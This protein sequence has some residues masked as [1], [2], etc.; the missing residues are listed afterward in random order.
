MKT[1]IFIFLSFIKLLYST[2]AILLD[3]RL[4]LSAYFNITL[5]ETEIEIIFTTMNTLT[6]T[7]MIF[8]PF[9]NGTGE[10]SNKCYKSDKS[11]YQNKN[12][13]IYVYN[14]EKIEGPIYKDN[15]SINGVKLN[16]NEFI[17]M[18][19]DAC[20]AIFFDQQFLTYLKEKNYISNKIISFGKINSTNQ[21]MNITIGEKYDINNLLNYDICNMKNGV[22]GCNLN[23][24]VVSNTIEDF[25]KKNNISIYNFDNI[26]IT[27]EFFI[28][29]TLENTIF[30]PENITSIIINFLEKNKFICKK[31][32]F[33]YNC[34]SNNSILFFIFGNKGIKF[35]NISIWSSNEIENIYFCYQ[36][37]PNLQII[38]DVEENKIIFHSDS[39]DILFDYK[40]SIFQKWY[41]WA[42]VIAIIII[43]IILCV[44]FY[45][46]NSKK[47]N[48]KN[49]PE[50]LEK[51]TT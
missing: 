34:E 4:I 15:L 17:Y 25:K 51:L 44:A 11:K 16:E 40:S 12:G 18:D 24:I 8:T 37:I 31:H 33:G 43:I 23:Q 36:T 41:F 9:K 7:K 3:T 29:F 22:Y 28:G 46:Y 20:G 32:I 39:N 1:I 14:K 48:K 27:T 19:F 45:F 49:N 13:T 6:D 35:N 42:I 5:N 38:L 2:K 50:L 21:R 30:I 10:Y 47:N 26:T